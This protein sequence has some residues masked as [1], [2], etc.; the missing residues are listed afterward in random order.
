MKLCVYIF[1]TEISRRTCSSVRRSRRIRNQQEPSTATTTAATTT[2]ENVNPEQTPSTPERTTLQTP[3]VPLQPTQRFQYNPKTKYQ[4]SYFDDKGVYWP[5]T[6][7][8]RR[9]T[10]AEKLADAAAK[11]QKKESTGRCLFENGGEGVSKGNKT[12]I[13]KFLLTKYPSKYKTLNSV[14]TY[15]KR[16]LDGIKKR[17]GQ[18]S[19]KNPLHD[20]RTTA[21]KPQRVSSNAEN[22]RAVEDGMNRGYL[23]ASCLE[24][25]NSKT[26]S[27]TMYNAYHI[28]YDDTT[29]FDS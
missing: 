23:V 24:V 29:T 21:V 17:W 4:H 14:K 26:L 10:P 16:T 8:R 9:K 27:H 6:N 22:R 18:D 13:A 19:S 7:K 2:S 28:S 3:S 25:C 12:S 20:G 5:S 1:T 15:V 11:K